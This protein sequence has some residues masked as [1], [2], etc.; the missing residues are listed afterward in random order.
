MDKRNDS[1]K[2]VERRRRLV[3][4]EEELEIF[5]KEA[6]AAAQFLYAS[7]ALNA[8]ASEHHRVLDHLNDAPLFWNTTIFALQKAAIVA[9]GRIFQ[10]DT[11][12]NVARLLKAAQGLSVF[13]KESLALRKQGD[14]P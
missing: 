14:S 11:A 10:T 12:H 8:L 1:A 5:R 2:T 13:S 4:F 9:L 6:N 7:L 3:S